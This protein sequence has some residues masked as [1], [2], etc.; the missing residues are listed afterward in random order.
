[1]F[2]YHPKRV[3]DRP[4]IRKTAMA[5]CNSLLSLVIGSVPQYV[6]EVYATRGRNPSNKGRDSHLANGATYTLLP[7]GIKY[8]HGEVYDL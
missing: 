4:T 5:V 8:D 6:K 7:V 1:M 3:G 2:S